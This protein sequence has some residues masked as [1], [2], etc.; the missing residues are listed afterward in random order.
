MRSQKKYSA[1]MVVALSFLLG[2][3]AAHSAGKLKA[4]SSE[5]EFQALLES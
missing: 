2:G 4:F 1:T 5:A 3:C